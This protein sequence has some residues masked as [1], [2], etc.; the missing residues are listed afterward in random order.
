MRI[1]H[2]PV[3]SNQRVDIK[4]MR[5]AISRSTCV[6]VGSAPNFPTGSIDDI[7]AIAQLGKEFDIPVHVDACLGGF[8]IP[9]MEEAGYKIPLFDFR[10]DGVTSISCDVHKYGYSPK[11]SS[12]ILYRKP[13]YLHHQYMCFSDWTGGI[14]ATPTFAGSRCGLA[15]SLAWATLLHYGRSGYI[16]R[17]KEIIECARHISSAVESDIDGLRLLGSPDV[18][19]VAFTSDSF[20]IYALIDDMTAL[21]WNLNSL[22]NPAGKVLLAS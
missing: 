10:L 14:Y 15:I 5:E 9:F 18:S 19:V 20:N 4:R 12:V 3:K 21:G 11:G 1:R 7:E 22:Q 13:E 16:Q 17:T 8:L 2:V 6:L